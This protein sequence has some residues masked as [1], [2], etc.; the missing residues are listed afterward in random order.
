[1]ALVSGDPEASLLRRTLGPKCSGGLP[2]R[3]AALPASS[4]SSRMVPWGHVP[5][6][7]ALE[8]LGALA[9][10]WWLLQ[11]AWWLG[12]VLLVYGLPRLGLGLG[13]SL[14][15]Q[16]AW[17]VVTGAT[18]G[19][20]RSYAHELARRGLNV[21]LV[22]RDL[23]KLH[24]EAEEIERRHGQETRIIQADLSGGPELYEA[25]ETALEGLDV[26][27]L[28]NNVGRTYQKFPEKLLISENLSKDL[29]E[30]LN[31][32][33]LSMLQMTRIVLPQ[34]V[35]RGRGVIINISSEAGKQPVPYLTLYA[36]TKVDE[37]QAV[38]AK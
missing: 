10:A 2:L 35:A 11:G 38:G 16:G 33:V 15:K 22:S 21:V 28:V 17:A 18:S 29:T 7:S 34:M 12:H 31:C 3:W 14:R 27:V 30:T 9:A 20:G 23:H 5:G 32:N 24:R 4:Q 1:M 36:A 26:G 25:V 19:I 37:D 6:G 8:V 13:I